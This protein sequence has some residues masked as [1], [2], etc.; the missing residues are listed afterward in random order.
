[1]CLTQTDSVSISLT[2]SLTL[3][4]KLTNV[5]KTLGGVFGLLSVA[6]AVVSASSE[7]IVATFLE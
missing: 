5:K 4:H 2:H 1:M 7:S 3:M 6:Q